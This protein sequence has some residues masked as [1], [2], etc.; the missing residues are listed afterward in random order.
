MNIRKFLT[1]NKTDAF[2]ERMERKR[3]LAELYRLCVERGLI[4]EERGC[5]YRKR[6]IK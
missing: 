4:N 3:E 5:I 1:A 6:K 2:N